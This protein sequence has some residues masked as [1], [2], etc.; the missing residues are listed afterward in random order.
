MKKSYFIILFAAVFLLVLSLFLIYFGIKTGTPSPTVINYRGHGYSY[1]YYHH[2]F[3]S[4]DL[5]FQS[6]LLLAFGRISFVLSIAFSFIFTYLAANSD[7]KKNVKEEKIE[8]KAIENK[9]EEKKDEVI[10]LGP[11]EEEK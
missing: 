4:N 9:V 2:S 3:S 11:P 5:T 10:H 8:K 6:K 1:S 7:K